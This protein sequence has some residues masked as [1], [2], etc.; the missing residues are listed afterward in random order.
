MSSLNL[1]PRIEKILIKDLIMKFALFLLLISLNGLGVEEIEEIKVQDI[2]ERLRSN[3]RLKDSIIATEVVSS[4][5]IE[6]KQANNLSEAIRDESGIESREGCSICGMRR[7][8]INGMKGEHTTVLMDGIPLNSTVSSYYG[9]DALG[10]SGIDQI[11]ISRGAGAALIAPEAIGGV[12]NIIRK[13]ATEDS[14]TLD[15]ALGDFG[16]KNFSGVL[17]KVG[18][19]RKSGTTFSAQYNEMGQMDFDN[20]GVNEA[21]R[22]DSFLVGAK[23]FIDLDGSNNLTFDFTALKSNTFGGPMDSPVF[24]PTRSNATSTATAP[25]FRNNDVREDLIGNP[26]QVTETVQVQRNEATL[27]YTHLIDDYSNFVVKQSFAT[28]IQDSWYEGSDYY[29]EN[30]TSFSDVQYN[31]QIG[32]N[33]FFTIGLDYKEEILRSQS[34][35]FFEDGNR[36]KDNYNYKSLGFYIR[37][38]WTPD[39]NIEISTALRVNKITTD[40]T[41]KKAE[42]NEIDET[43]FAPR[44]HLKWGH[45]ENLTSRLGAGVGYRA[46]LTFFESEHGILDD[47]FDVDISELEKSQSAN[48][49]ISYDSDRLI[50]NAGLSHT[51]VENLAFVDPS[52]A[53]PTLQNTDRELSVSN[54][55]FTFG[56]QISK[57]FNIGFTFEEFHY[58]K[59]YKSLLALAAVEQRVRLDIEYETKNYTFNIFVNWVGER[60][61]KDYGY[62]NRFNINNSGTLSSEKGTTAE[63]YHTIDL[64]GSYNF[65]KD[66]TLYVGVKNAL[67]YTQEESPLFYDDNGDFDVIHIYGPLRGRQIYAGLQSKF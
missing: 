46:P 6:R 56:Y 7:V 16:Y 12:I 21:P 31:S 61:L 32:L 41:D 27:T 34:K 17:T 9:F 23:H 53:T 19:G 38:I 25:V 2:N 64:K 51:S 1:T 58:Q 59:A 55:D 66:Y 15:L 20:N 36:D 28:Q 65:A 35:A 11:E 60:D 57:P 5:D 26:D 24:K 47:G 42:G 29:H 37:D 48:Y 10:T 3:G 62:S 4:K 44:F 13:K 18:E 8:R 39:S 50:I 54:Y 22:T 33:H 40:W 43:I 14:A 67:D 30:K 49:V 52:A 45:S 63:A